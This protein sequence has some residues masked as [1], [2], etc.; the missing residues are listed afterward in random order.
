MPPNRPYPSHYV[1][2]Y[3]CRDGALLTLR[4]IR[5][6]DEPLLVRLH[7]RLSAQTVYLRYLQVFKLSLRIAHDRLA[8]R[9]SIDYDRELAL[10][11]DR[12]DPHTGAHEIIAVGRLIKKPG[13]EEAEFALLVTDQY[14]GAG[15][16]SQVL[17]HLVAIAHQ[18]RLCRLTGII[19][20][21]NRVMQHLCEKLGFC[22]K[23]VGV[24]DFVQVVLELEPPLFPYYLAFRQCL[25][26]FP[27]SGGGDHSLRESQKPEV[28][29]S[30]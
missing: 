11:A 10:V 3:R 8:Q 29:Q 22:L 30:F 20:P 23:C 15:L 1:T 7:E 25:F 4:P 6:E 24:Q 18:E 26:E 12:T 17:R 19:H 16:G 14:Q 5:P 9:C 2:T 13:T 28:F 21:E 27:N